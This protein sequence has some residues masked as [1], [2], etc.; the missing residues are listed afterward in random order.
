MTPLDSLQYLKVRF[1]IVVNIIPNPC[2]ASPC[3]PWS[4]D[5]GRRRRSH[6]V[7]M[8]AEILEEYDHVSQ[9]R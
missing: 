5:V 6:V 9:E 8:K 1:M 4:L 2:R 3:V 7:D